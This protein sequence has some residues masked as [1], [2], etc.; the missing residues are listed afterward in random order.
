MTNFYIIHLLTNDNKV[1]KM[2]FK[3]NN[4]T[5]SK[6]FVK[7]YKNKNCKIYDNTLNISFNSS[8]EYIEYVKN[9]LNYHIETFN[10][11][12]KE[13]GKELNI[14]EF[15]F[16]G[17]K[18]KDKK[19]LNLTHAKFESWNSGGTTNVFDGYNEIPECE[20]HLSRINNNIH[21]LEQRLEHYYGKTD[22][23][24]IYSRLSY[25]TNGLKIPINKRWYDSFSMQIKFGDLRM[26]YSTQGKNL[27]H[28]FFDDDLIHL[29][30]NG[31]PSPQKFFNSGIHAY[32]GGY[33]EDKILFDNIKRT[34]EEGLQQLNEWCELHKI[35]EKYGIKNNKEQCRG[36]IILGSF[37]PEGDLNL[38]STVKEVIDYYSDCI[39]ILRHE[40]I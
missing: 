29:E 3:L 1:K 26:N 4:S 23:P 16:S 6:D 7:I 22:N 39:K 18:D 5:A 35:E 11:L 21:M 8:R 25:T 9:E 27:Q 30:G 14:D 12:Q 37:Y 32:F 38:N 40:I 28:L 10:N 31:K 34:H 19:F 13:N 20:Y 15:I 36:Y 17:D 33:S 2:I 24:Y